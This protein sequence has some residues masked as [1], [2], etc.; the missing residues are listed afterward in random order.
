MNKLAEELLRKTEATAPRTG[1][2]G[3]GGNP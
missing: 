2:A 3:G 1:A